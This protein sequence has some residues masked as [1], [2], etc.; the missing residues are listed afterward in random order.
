MNLDQTVLCEGIKR[1]LSG[2]CQAELRRI[3][4]VIER[5]EQ[6]EGNGSQFE[7]RRAIVTRSRYDGER[8]YPLLRD[9]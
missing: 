1:T 5:G 8:R 7:D 2:Q 6:I 4:P 9:D 3:S